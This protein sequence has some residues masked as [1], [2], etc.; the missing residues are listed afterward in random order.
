M[1]WII[2]RRHRHDHNLGVAMRA[3]H[4]INGDRDGT[5]VVAELCDPPNVLDVTQR[6]VLR[7]IDIATNQYGIEVEFTDE[8][9][10]KVTLTLNTTV[11]ALNNMIDAASLEYFEATP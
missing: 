7:S 9:D 1:S 3:A 8:N 4:Y 2:D 10:N 5:A 11:R 6:A